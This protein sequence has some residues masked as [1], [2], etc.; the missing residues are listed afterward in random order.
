VVT[1]AEV[2]V[3]EEGALITKITGA[4]AVGVVDLITTVIV[5]THPIGDLVGGVAA[6]VV[7]SIKMTAA[8]IKSY[9]LDFNDQEEQV[10]TTDTVVGMTI[11]TIDVVETFSPISVIMKLMTPAFMITKKTMTTMNSLK[12]LVLVTGASR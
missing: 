3:K 6:I 7:V 1:V 11:L 12:S 10:R 4:E 5:E 8:V 9:H 2:K